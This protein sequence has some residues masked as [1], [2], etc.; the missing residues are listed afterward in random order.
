MR[1]ALFCL[2][3]LCLTAQTS[4]ITLTPGLTISHSC[5]VKPQL[6]T[7]PAD[8]ATYLSPVDISSIKAVITIEGDGV[9]VDFQGAELE[10]EAVA[11]RPDRFTGLA[12]LVKGKNITLKNALVH[13]YKVAVLGLNAENIRI[14][15]CNFSYN[16]RPQLHST[17]EREDF[18]D[19]LSYHH[20]EKDEWLRYGAAIYLKN[21]LGATVK[22]CRATGGQNGLLM[23]GCEGALV[24]NNSFHY[25][26]GVGVGLYRSSRNKI[27]HNF[28][29]WNVRGF[30]YGFYARGQDSAGILLYEQSAD[31]LIAFNSVT[32][33]GDGLFLWAGQ[34]TMDSGEGGCN[35]NLVYGNDF[36]YAPTNGV[37]I[38]FSRNVIQGNL[39][40][41]C[42]YGIWGGYSFNS[43]IMGN[44]LGQCNTGI[45]IEHG[46][47]DT[48]ARN[49]FVN[50]T[51]GINL[52]ARE[53]QP[54]DWGYAQKR[55]VR[56]RDNVIDRNVF[57][58]VHNPLIISHSHNISVNG[59][60]LFLDFKKVLK[61]PK[62]NE[63]LKFYRND[64]YGTQAVLDSVWQDTLL[65][66]F[67]GLNF[68]HIG[69]PE[70][71][72]T[73]LDIPLRELHEPDSLP[74]GILAVLPDDFPHGKQFILVD[75]WGPFDFRRPVAT[76][77]TVSGNKY[78][79]A[80][81]GPSGHW[82]ITDMKG[83]KSVSASTGVVPA[84][85]IVACD[86]AADGFELHFEYLGQQDIT[87]EFGEKI[88]KG[89]PYSFDF[90]HFEKKLHWQLQFFNYSGDTPPESFDGLKPVA[91]QSADDL[92]FA[93][94]DKPAEG[95]QADKFATLGTCD[96]SIA[97]GNYRLF[98]T[99]DDGVRVYLDGKLLLDDW[100][101]HEPDSHTIPLTLGGKHHLRVEHFE[102]GGF[103]C[104]SLRLGL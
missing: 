14:E 52:W 64:I 13:G 44:L 79:L 88:P 59:Q 6:Y 1:I 96:F 4:E 89:R 81:I 2:F 22:G 93:W 35:D 32:H 102:N 73:P 18:S 41:Q 57:L 74:D 49:L 58:S 31:N 97:P 30:S 40:R 46:Q 62:P 24:Y 82:K 7:L 50:D 92:Y 26:S 17:R 99:S 87:T 16:Y 66:P 83:V 27:M 8:T 28:L 29:D 67:K 20:N 39:I 76:I 75:E 47:N 51:T 103:G 11:N 10:S 84:T 48:I 61:A 53:S 91:S 55:D 77:D 100:R 71:P 3:P 60:N 98:V 86:P 5:T 15:D 25:N 101:V 78:A 19:W 56:S 95:V 45:A 85:L 12:I 54:A 21:C 33:S 70:N 104:L 43:K 63:G 65:G 9:V 90:S 80:L 94:W 69:A 37:E 36:S 23:S 34:S 68:S 42:H 72:Y 38:T